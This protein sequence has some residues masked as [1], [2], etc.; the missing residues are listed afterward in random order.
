[1]TNR[2]Q[3]R[4][5][6]KTR[7]VLLVLLASAAGCVDAV[8]YLALDEVF[9]ANMT[10]NTVLLAISV[11][12]ADTGAALRS[13]TALAGFVAGIGLGAL[14]VRRPGG[15]R[16]VWPP[17]VTAALG[18][19]FALLL[20]LWVGWLFIGP[21]SSGGYLLIVAAALAMGVQTAAVRRLGVPGVSTTYVSG[22]LASLTEGAVSRVYGRQAS[23][24][25]RGERDYRRSASARGGL[26]VP[27]D[28]WLA[29]GVGALI[30]AVLEA[31]WHPGALL[32]PAV[33]VA[34][35]ASG[36]AWRFWE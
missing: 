23:R 33:I 14:I 17:V 19:E 36:A 28:V 10:G 8:S 29:Y 6:T 16:R 2:G 4:S 25:P 12:Q 5:A 26:V 9:T 30:G 7:N 21:G 3:T 13:G 22:T 32:V 11:G 24:T 1:M 15:N 20:A 34:G 31:W 35:V 18:L 27:A